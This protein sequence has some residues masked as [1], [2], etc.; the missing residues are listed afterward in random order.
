MRDT[1]ESIAAMQ[2]P[3]KSLLDERKRREEE[4]TSQRC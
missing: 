2:E 4:E 1:A 3:F